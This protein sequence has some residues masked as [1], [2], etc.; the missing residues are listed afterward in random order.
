MEGREIGAGAMKA[1]AD[2]G[3]RVVVRSR[4]F[5]VVGRGGEGVGD[6]GFGC[7]FGCDSD[8][9]C[10]C[11][12]GLGGG[13]WMGIGRCRSG[14]FGGRDVEA[15]RRRRSVAVRWIQG[16]EGE[17][18]LVLLVVDVRVEAFER[19]FDCVRRSGWSGFGSLLHS[20]N[21]SSGRPELVSKREIE[22][23]SGLS[24]CSGSAC[25]FLC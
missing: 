21:R 5:G 25:L 2:C 23:D 1:L 7:S 4:S 10:G 3:A 14:V 19:C 9:G 20:M 6:F 11:G 15:R 22:R 24:T 13:V 18:H 16:R 12:F 8:C 17:H